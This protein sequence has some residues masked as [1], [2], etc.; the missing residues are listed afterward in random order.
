MGYVQLG[1]GWREDK[2]RRS[3]VRRGEDCRRTLLMM[4]GE[5]RSGGGLEVVVLFLE[6]ELGVW[7]GL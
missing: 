6:R 1:G 5:S 4:A 2:S 7:Q 3:Q